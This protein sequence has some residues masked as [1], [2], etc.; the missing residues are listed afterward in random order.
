MDAPLEDQVAQTLV[1]DLAPERLDAFVFA[2]GI[3]PAFRLIKSLFSQNE[4]DTCL[5]LMLLHELS[6][7]GGRRT[8]EQIR[9][10]APFLDPARVDGLVRSLKDGAWLSLRASDQTYAPTSEGINLLAVLSGADLGGVDPSNVLAR[11]AQTA[12]FN[13]RLSGAG[14]A[15]GLLLDQ[16]RVLL[17]DQ[18]DE[19]QDVLRVGRPYR[20][21]AWAGR[22]HGRQLQTVRGVLD[23]LE[24][25]LDEAS[26]E[27]Q[28]VVRLH[29]AMQELVRMHTSIHTR[30]RD[31]NLER[32]H[33]SDAGY[34][35]PQLAEAVL[36]AD[37]S[38]LEEVVRRQ[39]VQVPVT[40]PDLGFEELRQRFH[41]ARRRARPPEKPFE[42]VAPEV[43]DAGDWQPAEEDHAALLR[44]RLADLLS[45]RSVLLPG[46]WL[47]GEAF[48]PDA[49][50]LATLARLEGLGE[51]GTVGLGDGR[52]AKVTTPMMQRWSDASEVLDELPGGS[53][54]R[55][56][57]ERLPDG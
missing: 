53:F 43:A 40:A 41:G 11:A 33:T 19:A 25:H 44:A 2:R 13:A 15:V 37:D 7:A 9:T 38:A 28:R 26:Q 12:E 51:H 55:V 10:T 20:M 14:N 23:Q 31:W 18:V 29:E 8:M 5:K 32:L 1:G 22:H 56:V 30:L 42:Y 36:A 47:E 21:I 49:F 24:G 17:G 45:T 6:R 39:L 57:I 35:V 16:L 27:F 34:A 52:S 54:S 50:E 3:L 48:A 46:D 4:L